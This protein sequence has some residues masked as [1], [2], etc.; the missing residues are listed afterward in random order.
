MKSRGGYCGRILRI[1]L[2]KREIIGEEIDD[3]IA[4]N[5]IGGR[6]YSAWIL[7]SELNPK[8]DPLSEENKIIFMAG[9]FTGTDVPGSGRISISSKSP[10]TGTIF[11]SSMGGSFGAYLKA[12]GYDGLILSGSSEKP[13]YLVISKDGANIEDANSIWG[14][15]TRKTEEELRTKYPASSIAE[16]GPAGENMVLLANIMSDGR[17]AG[18][19]GLGAVLGSK[20]VKAIVV[21]GDRKVKIAHERLYMQLVKKINYLI[22]THPVTGDNGS[23]ALH[24]TAVLVHPVAMAG[25]MP[26]NNFEKRTLAYDEVDGFSG[27]TIREKY[28]VRRK[29][30]YRCTTACGR[31]IRIGE[32]VSKCP[33]YESIAMIG[34]NSGFFDFE[35]QIFPLCELCDELGMDTISVGNSLGFARKMGIIRNFEDAKNLVMDIAHN[36]SPFSKGVRYASKMLEREEE[37]MQVKGLEMPAYNPIGVKGTAL[38]YATSNRGACHLRAYTISPEILHSPQFVDPNRD[39]GKAELVVKLQNAFAVYDSLIMCKYYSFALFTSLEYELDDI[40]KLLSAITGWS[41]TSELLHEIGAR[42]YTI[43]RIFNVEAGI[44]PEEDILPKS[45]G[46]DIS[47]LLKSYYKLRGWI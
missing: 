12:A 17:A 42:I 29:G 34:P 28:F 7:Y 25:I 18:R 38:A 21:K 6:G 41:Y 32:R 15:S 11:D 8:V 5:F 14:K 26:V 35:N 10:L 19:G 9:P 24:G 39:E 40:A 45:L 33:E 27:E 4:Y 44:G 1:D 16:I 36:R 37:A 22:R 3:K 31:I 2:S 47:D 43:E 30:C 20:K 13:V 23:L 46:I